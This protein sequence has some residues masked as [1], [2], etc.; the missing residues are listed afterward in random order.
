[1]SHLQPFYDGTSF[2][3]YQFFG[4]HVEEK[5]V[6][7]RVYA[8]NAHAVALIGD[9]NDWQPAPLARE[10]NPGV[11][12]I[13][14]E[15]AKP[16]QR[17]KYRI[18]E[19]RGRTRDRSDPFGFGA[20]LRP[21]TAS[22]I[23]DIGRFTFTDADWMKTRADDFYNKPLNI[24]EVHLGSWRRTE[25]GGWLTFRTAAPLLIEYA[26]EHGFTHLE[27]LPL[28]E[29]PSDESWGYQTTGFFSPTARYGTAEDLQFFVNECHRAGIGVLLDFVPVHFAPDDFSLFEFDGTSIYEYPYD[30]VGRSEW[31]SCNFNFDRP[32]VR[33]FLQ[34]SANYWLSVY[35]FDGLRMDAVRNAIYWQGNESRGENPGGLSFLRGLN[36]GLKALDPS[37]ILIAEDSSTYLKVTAPT[38]YDGLGFDFKWDLGWMH[39]T[40]EFFKIPPD[41]RGAHYGKLCWSMHYFHNELYLLPLSHDEVVHG[42]ATILQRMWGEYEQKF[43]QGR[44]LYT[45]MFT[46]PGK[47]LN[48]MGNEFGQLREWDEGREQDWDLLKYPLHDSFREYF[49]TLARLYTVHPAL[50]AN[51]YHPD[52]FRWLENGAPTECVY[53]YERGMG[54]DRLIVLLNLS[55]LHH[56]AFR[57]G[58][59]R[60]AAIREVLN[61]DWQQY[62][63]ATREK[64]RTV[65]AKAAPYKEWPYSFTV[66]LAPFGSAIYEIKED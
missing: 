45:Y 26:K 28:S 16:G 1:M 55:G 14:V 10:E 21:A 38:A 30:D 50:Y 52:A 2:T 36:S 5:G 15:G 66:E 20:E 59:D 47:K 29:H 62:G 9:F 40:L 6:L 42:K 31:G 64:S 34:S 4:A 17:Y 8:P 12:Y 27:L 23:A 19:A 61:S 3:A 44:T 41:Q 32:E 25:D 57:F 24:Y 56:K 65:R 11:W 51:E 22:V 53:V 49:S 33:S 46:H 48:F 13:W 60:K 54:D 37:V 43:P 7:F 58:Y 18:D 63:G 35:H 39:D